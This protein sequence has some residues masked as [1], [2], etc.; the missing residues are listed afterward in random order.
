M[1]ADRVQTEQPTELD[2]T[3]LRLMAD[4]DQHALRHF[5]RRHARFVYSLAFSVVRNESD[6]EE[7]TQETFWRVWQHAGEFDESRATLRGWLAMLTR[8]IAIDRTRSRSYKNRESE[9]SSAMTPEIHTDDVSSTADERH[10]LRFQTRRV[11]R[12]LEELD[13]GQRHLIQMSYF[14]GLSHS[15][16]ASELG[17][18]LGTVKTRLREA[19]RQLRQKL[20]VEA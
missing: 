11:N 1:D 13:E 4:K 16:M 3:L 5:Y 18:P 6:A 20:M 19:I 9:V 12:A 2:A 7:V 8:R 14:E 15:S 17:T 10:L